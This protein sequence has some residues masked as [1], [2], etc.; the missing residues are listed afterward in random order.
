MIILR[1]AMFSRF[2]KFRDCGNFE[3][4]FYTP[5]AFR[6]FAFKMEKVSWAYRMRMLMEYFI[7]YRIFYIRRGEDWAG[8]CIVTDGSN[9]RY[10][11]STAR[12]II[13]GRYYIS[14][15]HRGAGLAA[16]MLKEVLDHSGLEY[17]KAYAYI[18]SGNTASH[19]TVLKL[20]AEVCGHFN[21]VGHFR[22]IVMDDKGAYTL[23]RYV[24]ERKQDQF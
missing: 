3:L 16:A 6:A 21:K 4:W 7:G 10:P 9:P 11:F 23:Y 8:Y 22:R 2:E 12:D 1:A 18:H 15:P 17:E 20:G 24:S 13:F 14:S 19:K 5:S